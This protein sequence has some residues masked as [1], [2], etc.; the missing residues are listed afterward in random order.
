[1][2]GAAHDT[3]IEV[4]VAFDVTTRVGAAGAI[5]ASV[6]PVGETTATRVSADR[7]VMPETATGTELL[8][9]KPLPN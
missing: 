6:G 9:V 3:C 8:V 7:P 1:L 5:A 4:D 2:A